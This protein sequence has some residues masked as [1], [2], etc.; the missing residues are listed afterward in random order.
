MYLHPNLFFNFWIM[1]KRHI[2]KCPVCG[3]FFKNSTS[4][5]LRSKHCGIA[6]K[7][8]PTLKIASSK[9][10]K[11][12]FNMPLVLN[13]KVQKILYISQHPIPERFNIHIPMGRRTSQSLEKFDDSPIIDT[14]VCND[15]PKDDIFSFIKDFAL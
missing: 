4:H 14:N 12:I 8:S 6:R 5:L 7:P 15:I 13:D 9:K 3:G 11:T 10:I 1:T 2:W